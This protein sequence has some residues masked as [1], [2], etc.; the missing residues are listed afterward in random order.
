MF[1]SHPEEVSAGAMTGSFAEGG[2]LLALSAE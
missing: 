2:L 1:L